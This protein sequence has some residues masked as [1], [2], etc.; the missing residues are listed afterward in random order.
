[1]VHRAAAADDD[2]CLVGKRDFRRERGADVVTREE[3][4]G[5]DALQNLV[6]FRFRK[7]AV[8]KGGPKRVARRVEEVGRELWKVEPPVAPGP[9]TEEMVTRE[10]TVLIDAQG[11]LPK[12]TGQGMGS[13][14]D[15]GT[16]RHGRDGAGVGQGAEADWSIRTGESAV[17]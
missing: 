12:R 10:Q 7:I 9:L 3:M 15:Q 4:R 17:A 13:P 2:A 1:V 16:V 5:A 8:L 6:P 11:E 14:K